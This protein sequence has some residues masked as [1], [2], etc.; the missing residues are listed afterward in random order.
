MLAFAL[1]SHPDIHCERTE[2]LGGKHPVTKLTHVP[3]PAERVGLALATRGYEVAG[4][5]VQS[6]Q[7]MLNEDVRVELVFRHPQ[8]IRLTR[9]GQTHVD[10]SEL[11]RRMDYFT[12]YRRQADAWLVGSGLPVTWLTYE[13]VTEFQDDVEQLPQ[14][15]AN[16][17]TD[18]L[19]VD[20]RTLSVDIRKRVPVA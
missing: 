18:F 7:L 20:R 2:P 5:T 3:T 8:V 12:E 6:D 13:Q 9:E 19:G 1:D 16:Q 10:R 11:A 17:L 15:I 14:S 4:C